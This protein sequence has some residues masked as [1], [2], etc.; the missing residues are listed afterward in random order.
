LSSFP[1][2]AIQV[3]IA[4]AVNINRPKQ[5]AYYNSIQILY[6]GKKVAEL[7]NYIRVEDQLAKNML[8]GF[9]VV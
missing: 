4:N 8:Y 9:L 6:F 5:I 2:R 1:P 7:L 3:L